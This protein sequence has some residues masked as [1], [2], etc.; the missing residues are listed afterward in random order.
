MIPFGGKKY[1]VMFLT[2]VNFWWGW[3]LGWVDIFCEF[4]VKDNLLEL[5][6]DVYSG[7]VGG[8]FFEKQ[9]SLCF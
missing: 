2:G 9:I 8:L 5:G 1:C 3:A 6:R 4:G 7:P